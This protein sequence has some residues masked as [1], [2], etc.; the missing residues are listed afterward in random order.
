M[1]SFNSFQRYLDSPHIITE[2]GMKPS[3]EDLYKRNNKIQFITKAQSGELLD[4]DGNK[5]TVKDKD[6]LNDLIK[7]I[8]DVDDNSD[9]DTSWRNLHKSAF[10]V[11]HSK[12]DKIANGFSTVSGKNPTG[13]DWESIIA[14][15]VNKIQGGKW[16]NGPEWERAEKF[17]GDWETQGMKLGQEFVTKLKV[18]KLEQLGAS[19]LPISKDW[20]GTNK[21]P[22]TDLI[23]GKRKISLKKAGGSQLLSAGKMEAISTIEAAMKMYSIDPKG[24]GRVLSLISDLENKMIKLTE[25]G[26]VGSIEK[27]RGEKKLSPTDAKKIA[28]LDQGQEYAQELSNKIQDIFNEDELMKQYFCWE[29]A[30]GITKFGAK[31]EGVANV[32]VTFKETG[33][34]T[35]ILKL[36][37]PSSAGKVLADGN[38]FYISFKSSSGSPPYLA[39]RSKKIKMKT[40]STQSTFAQIIQEECSKE[41]IGLQMLNEG[42]LEQLDEFKMLKKVAS[43]AKEIGSA[44]GNAA[45][46]IMD[47]I[48]KR[49]KAA[50]SFIKRQG[51][52]MINVMLAFFGFDISSIKVTGGGKY[53]IKM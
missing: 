2:G 16:N 3:G 9:L 49:V 25:K 21:T 5:L 23:D 43:K 32:I 40:E 26:T 19:T 37:S 36:D 1:R 51:A 39:L 13:E 12:V 29:A 45:K 30:T 34:I 14:V 47:A 7:L 8:S 20:K 50:F 33:T 35:D 24:K 53:P 52:K 42:K 44:I 41:D 11:A 31:S 4:I 18:K 22:K 17:W 38:D 28:E 15:A 46:K 10:G 48:L 6:A 27:L